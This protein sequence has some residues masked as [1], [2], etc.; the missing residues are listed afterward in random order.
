MRYTLTLLALCLALAFVPSGH[1]V[2]R[3]IV[4]RT[5]VTKWGQL[6][7]AFEISGQALPEGVKA[8]DF[9]ITGEATGWGA[10]SLHPFSCAAKAVEADGDGWRLVPE[11]F[12]DKYF[13]VKKMEVR[14]AG[15]DGL[16]FD[17]EDITR[18][19]T[20][21]ADDFELYED[22]AAQLSARVFMPQANEPVPVVIVFHGYGD[23]NNLLT[24]RTAIPWAEPGFQAVH[25][26]AVIAP[27]IPDALYTSEFVRNGICEGVLGWIDAQ[28]AWR[29]NPKR[30]YTMGN[31]FGGMTAI[32][33]AEQHPDRV[34]AVLALC[35]ALNYSAH[36]VRRLDALAGTPVAIAQAEHDETIPV[37][38]SR[39]AAAA[40]EAAGNPSVTLRIYT[41]DEMNAAGARLG[42][43]ET[44]S[45]HHVEL[46]VM[47]PPEFDR[48]AEWLFEQE[49][50]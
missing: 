6:P 13:Y 47:E 12:P 31:S 39:D 49:K 19:I 1:A 27:V 32:E 48:Y 17:L 34:A 42:S 4:A 45:F 23:T 28:A 7:L 46:A 35:P 44:Y 50:Q 14:C 20:P 9:T 22:P 25:P 36:G 29:V 5:E 8:T 43:S 33:M 37:Q 2:E 3:E 21:V 11:Q 30:V 18:T 38:V 41:D 24:Y 40:V 16:D 26:C 15:H 10:S